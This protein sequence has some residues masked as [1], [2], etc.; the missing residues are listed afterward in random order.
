MRLNGMIFINSKRNYINFNN[1]T[2]LVV[3][4]VLMVENKIVNV[5]F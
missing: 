3:K 5:V 4:C 2:N 1:L